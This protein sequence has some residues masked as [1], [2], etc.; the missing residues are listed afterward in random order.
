ML[1]IDEYLAGRPAGSPLRRV[2]HPSFWVPGVKSSKFVK[3]RFRTGRSSMNLELN[4]MATSARSVLSCGASV[5]T[6]T[7]S[8]GGADLE[9]P[10]DVGASV[11]RYDDVLELEALEALRL[12]ANRVDVRNQVRHGVVAAFVR[13]GFARWCL[14]VW[15]VTLIFAL[16]TAAPEGSV[17]VTDNAAENRLAKC[18]WRAKTA[19]KRECCHSREN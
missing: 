1:A 10:V 19:E 6:S 12:E 17:A 15:L 18:D 16:G 7:C 11:G 2:H 9:L 13:R 4:S 5:V 3:F 8:R 14:R